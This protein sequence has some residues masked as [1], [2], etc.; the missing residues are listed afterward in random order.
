MSPK[1]VSL[2][3]VL[4]LWAPAANGDE[5]RKLDTCRSAETQLEMTQC[6]A[7]E[8]AKAESAVRQSQE[9]V[10]SVLDNEAGALFEE[11]NQRWLEYRDAQCEFEASLYAG[12]SLA[13]YARAVCFS[14]ITWDRVEE[15]ET[16]IELRSQGA[17]ELDTPPGTLNTLCRE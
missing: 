12:G 13:G 1:T 17:G 9:R 11:A 14:S 8:L 3:L 10:E 2:M 5:G 4:S 16:V 7:K 15:L 6:A